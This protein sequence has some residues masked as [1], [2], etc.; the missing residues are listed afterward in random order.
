MYDCGPRSIIRYV[1]DSDVRPSIQE[2][3]GMSGDEIPIARLLGEE[4][5]ELPLQLG[6]QVNLWLF[7]ADNVVF[8]H[9]ERCA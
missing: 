3:V 4:L 5:D 8:V 6:M 9:R 1:I 7:N 2:H